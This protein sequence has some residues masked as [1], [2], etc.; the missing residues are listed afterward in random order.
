MYRA[1]QSLELLE[2]L[3]RVWL[4]GLGLARDRLRK[5]IMAWAPAESL[6]GRAG[7]LDGPPTVRWSTQGPVSNR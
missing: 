7:V 1:H 4:S 5:R 2:K 3:V 6:S